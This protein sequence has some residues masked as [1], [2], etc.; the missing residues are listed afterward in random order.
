MIIF[1]GLFVK[2]EWKFIKKYF[3]FV[4]A[5]SMVLFTP[6]GAIMAGFFME[7]WGRVN[8]IKIAIIPGLLGWL[9]IAIGTNFYMLL[10]GRIFTG[11]SS[12]IDYLF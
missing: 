2:V 12:G 6:V 11:L 1:S 10:L 5:S 7:A 4:P 9:L 3:S 8:T